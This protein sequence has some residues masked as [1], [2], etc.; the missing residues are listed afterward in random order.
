MIRARRACGAAAGAATGCDLG[1]GAGAVAT[2]AGA[3]ARRTV[4]T[5]VAVRRGLSV[6][7]AVRG[8]GAALAVC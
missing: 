5:G 1:A 4:R 2:A 3:G 8:A 6:C 7:G